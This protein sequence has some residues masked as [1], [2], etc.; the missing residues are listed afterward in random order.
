MGLL[1]S[2]PK[3]PI[4]LCKTIVLGGEAG[5]GIKSAGQILAH[6]LIKTGHTVFVY[7]E[8]P[9]LIRGGHNSVNVTYS[10]DPV[11]GPNREIDILV[12]LNRETFDLHKVNLNKGSVVLYD[13]D[14]FKITDEDLQDS[15]CELVE[16]PVLDIIRREKLPR[17]TKNMILVSAA[18]CIAGIDKKK[19]DNIITKKFS[20][21]KEILEANLKAIEHGFDTTVEYFGLKRFEKN[22]EKKKKTDVKQKRPTS[23]LL[24]GNDAISLG[25]IRAGL[26]FYSAYP[27][28][29]A[30]TVL[31]FMMSHFR[32]YDMVVKQAEDEIAAINMAIGASYAGARAM[33]GTSGGGFSLM[34]EALGLAAITETPLVLFLAQRPGP[35][36]GLPTWTGQA[37]LLFALHAS[38]DEFPRVIFTPTDAEECFTLAFKAFNIAEK[39]QIPVLILSDRLLAESLY[40]CKLDQSKLNEIDRG[41]LLSERQLDRIDDFNRYED[42][43][44]GVSPRSIP[45]QKNG[46]FLANSDEGN[47]KGFTDESSENRI[48]RVHK[49]FKKLAEIKKDMPEVN[50]YGDIRAKLCF[51]TWGSTKGTTL[52]AMRRLHTIGISTKHVAINHIEPF[53]SEIIEKFIKS[54]KHVVLIEGNYTSQLGKLIIQNTGYDIEHKILKYDG[55]P[56]YPDEIV[57]YVTKEVK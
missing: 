19:V 54:S 47:D 8:Y 9:S 39:Y 40:Q 29:P 22:V 42:T 31:D 20:S 4:T 55:R 34:V 53:P 33:V 2:T 10:L 52:E 46:I 12:C 30:S 36:T 38:Q 28:T 3:L 1:K 56:I 17:I 35:A 57:E 43:A 21:K 32:E 26:Q 50:V 27:M 45:G 6:S 24:T 5:E 48:K 44:N 18:L 49:R 11:Y 7:D 14:F 41:M 51:I 16:V 13:K 23:H 37:D 15:P 25:A